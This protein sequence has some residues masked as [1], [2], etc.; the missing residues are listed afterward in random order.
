MTIVFSNYSPKICKLG[1]FYFAQTLQLNKL[2]IVNFKFDNGTFEI[3]PENIQIKHFVVNVSFCFCMKLR[4]MKNLRVLISKVA[5]IFF[6]I[7]AKNTQI[8]NFL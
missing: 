8:R 5:I 4:I 7:P 6:Q 2:E 3:Q 1:I